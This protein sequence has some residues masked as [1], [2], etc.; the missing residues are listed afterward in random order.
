MRRSRSTTTET[1]GS[2]TRFSVAWPSADLDALALQERAPLAPLTTLRLGGPAWAL[3]RFKT[4][5]ELS[6]LRSLARREGRP[7][8]IL[9]GGSN[10]VVPDEGLGALVVQSKDQ[11]IEVEGTRLR[12]GAGVV[13]DE[14]VATAVDRGLQGIECLSGIPGSMG[15]APIQNIGA[16]GQ[17]LADTLVEVQVWDPESGRT[18]VFPKQQLGLGYRSSRFKRGDP[19]IVLAV[20][21]ELRR[22]LPILT[23]QELVAAAGTFP[24]EGGAALRQVRETVLRVRRSKSMVWDP[25]DP[26]HRSVGSF[27]MNPVVD[28]E[29]WTR[30]QARAERLARPA[31]RAF[32]V[33]GGHKLSAAWLIEHAGFEK[34]HRQGNVGLSTRHTLALVAHEGAT[35][36]ELKALARSIQ[37]GVYMVWGVALE[38]E[39]RFL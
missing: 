28:D 39:A 35:T 20:T 24:E 25:E 11:R 3:A 21:L 27:F 34:G 38:T 4:A 22:S 16:Y 14:V 19:G 7:L 6:G 13:W 2:S 33:E 23:H 10:V 17:E 12:V 36:A 9:G 15:A 31:P 30:V 8:M 32:P 18:R 37:V 5:E 26:N 29:R 1:A